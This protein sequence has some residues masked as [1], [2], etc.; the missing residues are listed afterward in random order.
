MRICSLS[1]LGCV[2]CFEGKVPGSLPEHTHSSAF[3]AVSHIE[4][5]VTTCSCCYTKVSCHNGNVIV[6]SFSLQVITQLILFHLN[7]RYI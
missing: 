5:S 1:M 2:G 4:T 7:K 3:E 6:Y